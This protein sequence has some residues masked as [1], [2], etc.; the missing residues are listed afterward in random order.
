MSGKNMTTVDE[1][2]TPAARR[3][4]AFPPDEQ[5]AGIVLLRELAGGE[6]VGAAQLAQALGIPVGD[7]EALIRES[8]LSPFVHADE[9]GRILGF[10]GLSTARM[11][12]RFTLNG[13]PL[14]TWCAV[15]SLF[16]PELLG[17]TA[18]VESRD[19]EGGDLVRLTVSPTGIEAVE[20]KGVVVSMNSP[21]VWETSSAAQVIATACH[22][23]FF[24]TSR[25]SGEHWVATHP[26]TVLL[27]LDEAFEWAKR[28]NARMFGSELARRADA[29]PP[30]DRLS[31]ESS[32][33]RSPR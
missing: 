20:P 24:F 10:W 13:Q 18:R 1:L 29:P 17:E 30:A 28:Q 8:G 6:P 25:A 5:R 23:I 26:K 9:G 4:P 16:L 2:W 31:P 14:W 22:F 11:H 32:E 7:A 21:D 19:P 3:F 27:S 33:Y 15:D 12:H